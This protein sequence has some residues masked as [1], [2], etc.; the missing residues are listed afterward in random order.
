MRMRIDEFMELTPAQLIY[1]INGFGELE[2][3]RR[4]AMANQV[5]AIL[6]GLVG[7][8]KREDLDRFI[9]GEE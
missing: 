1:A 4:R 7:K 2:K 3:N 6:S 8:L 5:A 9:E